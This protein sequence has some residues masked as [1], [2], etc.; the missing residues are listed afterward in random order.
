MRK[1]LA[2]YALLAASLAGIAAAPAV[3]QRRGTSATWQVGE[4]AA[5][6]SCYASMDF[7]GGALLMLVANRTYKGVAL[8]NNRFVPGEGAPHP[9]R[10]EFGASRR[11]VDSFGIRSAGRTGYAALVEPG[12][13]ADFARAASVRIIHADG[14]L[15][16][17][18]SLKGSAAAARRLTGC[19][20]RLDPVRVA[21]LPAKGLPLYD[22]FRRAAPFPRRAV[23]DLSVIINHED[24]PA[25]ARRAEEQGLSRMRLEVRPDG[26][27]SQCVILGSS[28]SN[29]LDSASCRLLRARARF[30][31]ALDDKG[32][33]VADTAFASI[34]W[35]MPED[36]P[37]APPSPAPPPVKLPGG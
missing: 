13:L 21:P 30:A 25:S 36:E 1:T 26:R 27:V 24:Y 16:A 7:E 31:P 15:V 20:E 29:A 12:F 18:L 8:G 3:A 5:G 19:V 34:L 2:R 22:A 33:A 10:W 17:A 28:G 35:R 11:G 4:M 6:G 32:V 9:L 23:I 37:T 14:E